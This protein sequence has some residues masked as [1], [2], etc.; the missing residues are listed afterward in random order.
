MS[1]S[2]KTASISITMPS[3]PA[4]L[5]FVQFGP[6][7]ISLQA[8]RFLLLP[9]SYML[10]V[11]LF[12]HER[13]SG[14]FIPSLKNFF[15]TCI[16]SFDLMHPVDKHK[17]YLVMSLFILCLICDVHFYTLFTKSFLFCLPAP[18]FTF[19]VKHSILR[20]LPWYCLLSFNDVKNFI[21]H[22]FFSSFLQNYL[23]CW[24]Y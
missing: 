10:Q 22:P 6:W 3:D 7:L 23:V 1:K 19:F 4:A 21:C 11:L 20:T 24:G 12:C 18:I 5:F 15:I 16:P 13:I 9:C 2:F 14:V 8:A 17:F